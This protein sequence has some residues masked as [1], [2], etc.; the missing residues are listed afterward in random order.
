M[1]KPKRSMK[2]RSLSR[3][4]L[5]ETAGAAPF[6][7]MGNMICSNCGSKITWQLYN[8]SNF[9]AYLPYCPNDGWGYM[10]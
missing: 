8:T 6:R 5:T 10:A 9:T 1:V 7:V 4:Q 2:L 3:E